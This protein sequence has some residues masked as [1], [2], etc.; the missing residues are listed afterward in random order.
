MYFY[1]HFGFPRNH[2]FK[3]LLIDCIVIITNFSYLTGAG[4]SPKPSFK[5]QTMI[6]HYQ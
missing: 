3:Q 1:D 5:A 4:Q 2:Y 6:L